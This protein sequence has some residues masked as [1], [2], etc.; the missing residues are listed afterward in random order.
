MGLEKIKLYWHFSP[1]TSYIHQLNPVTKIIFLPLYILAIF[2]AKNLITVMIL[3]LFLI[4][5]IKISNIKLLDIY[6]QNKEFALIYILSIIYHVMFTHTGERLDLPFLT[7]YSGGIIQGVLIFFRLVFL[8][9]IT[10]IISRTTT[11]SAL[12]SGF[13]MILKP[14]EKKGV[15]TYIFTLLLA[16]AIRFIPNLIEDFEQI[17]KA[18]IIRGIN[19]KKNTVKDK[20]SYT[21]SY[22]IP[23]IVGIFKRGEELTLALELRGLG[24]SQH[25]TVYHHYSWHKNDTIFLSVI[26]IVDLILII[27][28]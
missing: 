23:L 15:R 18:Q 5:L 27:L 9:N 25:R 1:D 17:K 6:L 28:A 13:G 10:I 22:V 2:L 16:L 19:E 20:I 24:I 14:L 7:L 4:L 11:T 26:I 8:Y 21:I 12:I 3:L